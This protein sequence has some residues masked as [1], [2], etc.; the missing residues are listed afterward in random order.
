MI[1]PEQYRRAVDLFSQALGMPD[2]QRGAFLDEACRGDPQIRE[3][4]ESLLLHDSNIANK[5]ASIDAG[6]GA[7]LL[8]GDIADESL[9]VDDTQKLPEQIGNYRIIRFHG[10]GGM[11][12][13]Y[14]AEQIN[15][16][17]RVALKVVRPGTGGDQLIKRFQ[18][19]AHVLGRL[20]HPGIA[21]VFEAGVANGQ[22]FIA[23][24]FI[25]GCALDE[26]ARKESLTKDQK[27][28]LVADLCDA[29]Q[30]AHESGV[31]HRDL[32]PSNILVDRTGRPKILDFGVARLTDMEHDLLTLQTDAGQLIGTLAYISPEQVAGDSRNIDARADIYSL[33]VILH[34]LFAGR[35]PHDI[36]KRGIADAA[37][38]I[39]DEEPT[40]L[41][42]IDTSYRGDI[43]TIVAK[44]ME[45]EAARRYQ[46]AAEMAEDIRRFLRH[47]PI[48]ARPA[49]AFYQFRKFARRNKGLVAGLSAAFAI[50]I[51]GLIT[52][53]Y[54]LVEVTRQR[55]DALNA[56]AIANREKNAAVKA[57]EE[58]NR[59]RDAAKKARLT[60]E[61][62]ADFQR[63]LLERLKPRD[64]GDD[65]IAALRREF[66]RVLEKDGATSSEVESSM[67]TLKELLLDRINETNVAYDLLSEQ[68]ASQAIAIIDGGFTKD[69]DTE[70]EVRFGIASLLSGLD[71]RERALPQYE[72]SMTLRGEIYGIDSVQRN[73]RAIYVAKTLAHLN[74][75]DEADA[76][77]RDALERLK[78]AKGTGN[79]D[80]ISASLNYGRF[81]RKLKRIDE[82][83]LV[84]QAALASSRASKKR[85]SE[86]NILNELGVLMLDQGR[87]DKALAYFDEVLALRPELDQKA[88]TVRITALN[89]IMATLF[90]E[91]RLKEAEPYARQTLLAFAALYGDRHYKTITA[92]NNLGRLL[93][94]T[95]RVDEALRLFQEAYDTACSALHPR[96]NVRGAASTNLIEALL[97]VE[98]PAEAEQIANEL[99]KIR[100][101]SNPPQAASIAQTLEQ[102]GLCLLAQD[103]FQEAQKA[104]Q[105]CV[106]HRKTIDPNHWLTHRA[107]GLVGTALAKLGR[108]DEAEKI[109]IDSAKAIEQKLTSIPMNMRERERQA[110]RSRVEAMYN[111]RGLS[112]MAAHWTDTSVE[113][114]DSKKP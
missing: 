104:F 65:I 51:V 66:E 70:A 77:Y 61:H 89:N 111:M 58:A 97:A 114:I 69:P 113:S 25:D 92:R 19:E 72:R 103:R 33:G 8:A 68:I 105:D 32:K 50:L 40:R 1:S 10:Q 106:E 112:N 6:K 20:Q 37:R 52:T 17:R 74:R 81:L 22:P 27:L 15:P 11:G 30:Y 108:Y 39:R 59:E 34:E 95:G 71:M 84:Q 85:P 28:E 16:K 42:S 110:A 63:N 5:T 23:M 48:T 18:R 44:A 38:I 100:G 109:L 91:N 101:Q 54:L 47:Q 76:L 94:D 49:S 41:G 31:I 55:N 107:R 57:R 86:V 67:A 7:N 79:R 73:Q 12:I 21:Q 75:N 35:L 98:R 13:V 87:T 26:Y 82:A 53:G 60:S 9:A 14:E 3:E 90:K 43:E 80:Y 83:I 45:K 56:Q 99:L 88:N 93:I 78:R 46:S 4:V 36:R 2:D 62:V 24:E 102:L 29:L 64:F 96:H